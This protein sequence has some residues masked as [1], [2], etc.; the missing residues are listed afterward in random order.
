[1]IGRTCRAPRC[2]LLAERSLA[3]VGAGHCSGG[4]SSE[5]L[6]AER[7]AV[8]M[9]CTVLG[10]VVMRHGPKPRIKNLTRT[11][12]ALVRMCPQ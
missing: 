10:L 6:A 12:Y 5:G 7:V 4:G 11:A 8:L 3:V 2:E 1:M 9:R